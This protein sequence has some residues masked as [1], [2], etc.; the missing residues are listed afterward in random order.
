MISRNE[1]TIK[2]QTKCRVNKIIIWS[3][4]KKNN[5]KKNGTPLAKDNLIVPVAVARQ[6]QLL[7]FDETM[8]EKSA[9][10][11][12]R[13]LSECWSADAPAAA[14]AVQYLEF[15]LLQMLFAHI[16]LHMFRERFVFFC[17]CFRFFLLLNLFNF[18]NFC[19]C[20]VKM[21]VISHRWWCVQKILMKRQ[22]VNEDD[23]W[24]SYDAFHN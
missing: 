6:K 19:T 5:R 24:N 4:K 16:I 2:R 1:K 10:K 11:Q 23:I 13:G 14:S 12:T 22:R 17:C 7:Y 8:N 21:L 18:I 15:N 3:P 9:T 20:C